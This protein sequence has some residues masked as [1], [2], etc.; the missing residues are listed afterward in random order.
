MKASEIFAYC[1]GCDT[2]LSLGM[3]INEYPCPEHVDCVEF[4][5]DDC[6]RDAQSRLNARK[7]T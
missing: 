7:H 1:S 5:C 4:Y 3:K 2:P 6:V